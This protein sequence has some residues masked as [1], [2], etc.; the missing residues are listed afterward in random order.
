MIAKNSNRELYENNKNSN[1][2]NNKSPRKRKAGTDDTQSQH[3]PKK[4]SA[5]TKTYD[6]PKHDSAPTLSQREDK[7]MKNLTKHILECGGKKPINHRYYTT[8]T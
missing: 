5:K 2:N 3:I 6:K 8:M 1:N 4:K 7:A